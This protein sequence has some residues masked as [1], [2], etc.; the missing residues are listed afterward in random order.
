MALNKLRVELRETI[1][2]SRAMAESID[3]ALMLLMDDKQ[4]L[5][6]I[7]AEICN[8]IIVGLQ[9]QDRLEQR[10]QNIEKIIN[11][12]MESENPATADAKQVWASL[13]LDELSKP[14]LSGKGAT[15]SGEIEF[16]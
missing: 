3:G 13:T 8:K 1:N 15:H 6:K 12:L 10:C 5:S 4:D 2:Q 16:F 9:A 11:V 7:R 14:E